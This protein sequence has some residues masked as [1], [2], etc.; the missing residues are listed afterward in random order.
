MEVLQ[1]PEIWHR[2]DFPL[3]CEWRK[4]YR[5]V[6]VG[7]DRGS[8]ANCFL[9]RCWNCQIYLGVDPYEEYGEMQW[10]RQADFLTAV[11]V[12]SKY[13]VAKLIRKRSIDAALSLSLV[14]ETSYYNSKFDFVYIDGSHRYE[15]VKSDIEA[16][17]PLVSDKG[18][19]AGHDW[20]MPSGDHAGVQRAVREFAEKYDLAVYTTPDDPQSWYVYKSGIPGAD[21]RRV[22]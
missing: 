22:E 12:F 2:A 19:L 13:P 8:F 14:T 20:A 5:V 10:D 21:W 11:D 7:V 16:W 18:I 4:L 1:S 17:W 15:D 3:L 9:S 6:E